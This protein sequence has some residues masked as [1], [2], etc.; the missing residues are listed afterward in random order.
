MVYFLNVLNIIEDR[1]LRI[2]LWIDYYLEKV[3]DFVILNF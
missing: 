1:V 3:R 2:R